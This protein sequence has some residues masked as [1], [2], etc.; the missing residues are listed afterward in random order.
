M[1]FA[2]LGR[3]HVSN[4]YKQCLQ[5]KYSTTKYSTS[6]YQILDSLSINEFAGIRWTVPTFVSSS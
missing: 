6:D 3:H 2:S 5:S 4:I 1:Y